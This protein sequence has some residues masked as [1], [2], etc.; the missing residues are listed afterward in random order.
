MFFPRMAMQT[1]ARNVLVIDSMKLIGDPYFFQD[2]RMVRLQRQVNDVQCKYFLEFLKPLSQKLGFWLVYE[3]DDVIKYEDIPPYNHGRTA[4]ENKGFFDNVKA[5]L[6][7]CDFLTVTCQNLKDYYVKNYGIDAAKVLVYPN[8]LPRWWIGQAYN[9]DMIETRFLKRQ[10]KPRVAFP[11]SSS[12][13]DISGKN[14]HKDDFTDMCPFIRSTYDQYEYVLIGHCPK[15]LEDL[16][17]DKKIEI[18]PGSDLLNYPREL[19]ERDI[20]CIVAPLVDNAFNNGKS[21]IKLLEGWSLGIP[22]IAQ[23]LPCYSPYT[24]TLFRD[25]NGLQ[26]QLDRLF[27]GK[28]QFMNEV[29]HNRNVVDYGDKM[30]PKGWWLEKNLQMWYDLY[31]MPQ[32]TLA[33][34]LTAKPKPSAMPVKIEDSELV[35][36]PTGGQD[37]V[38]IRL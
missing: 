36:A 4:Y 30:S 28:K 13:F 8:Y 5:M 37:G 9:T 17:R 38:V 24:S 1:I 10:K 25:N 3:V 22:V 26:N 11:M 12:H 7:A 16:A 20:Q 15:A 2:I 31:T 14:E 27:K 18:L 34:D 19:S 29:R 35:P 21:N 33:Y 23:D 6:E 32:R